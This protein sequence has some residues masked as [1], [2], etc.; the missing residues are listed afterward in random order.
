MKLKET[1]LACMV[2]WI[3]EIGSSKNIMHRIAKKL[4]N[5]K[6]LVARKLSKQ[7]KQ[8]LKNCL[9][10]NRRIVRLSQMMAQIRDLQNKMS[11]LSDERELLRSWFRRLLWSNP[12]SWSKFYDSEFEDFAALRLW[13]AAKY[14]EIVR[15]WKETFLN[16]QLFKK[17]NPLQSSTIQ[18][19]WHLLLRIWDTILQRQEGKK[20]SGKGNRWIRP[21]NHPHFQTRSGKL[22][23]TGGTYSHG[24]M[25]KLSKN[26]YDR[27][28]SWKI[29]WLYGISRLEVYLQNWS[30]STNSRSSG[31]P[32][33]SGSKKLRVPNQ[34][35]NLRHRHR[36]QGSR[37]FLIS[38]CLMRWLRQPWRSI[39]TRS[40][41]SEKE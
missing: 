29:S 22:D 8:E 10:L 16:A 7:D 23:H 1:K 5:W 12:R 11:S 33:C 41:T 17:D 20:E 35:T 24:G 26:S 31:H 15:V 32:P 36:F 28:E 6:E 18:R 39:S 40:Q 34:L 9:W 19:I 30:L 4:K 25:V 3:R 37:I 13:I 2:K 38:I 14:K 21:F 27:K